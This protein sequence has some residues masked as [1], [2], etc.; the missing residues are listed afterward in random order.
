ME[1]KL[2]ATLKRRN[3]KSKRVFRLVGEFAYDVPLKDSLQQLLSN[4]IIFDEVCCM[5]SNGYVIPRAFCC[6]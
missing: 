2:G 4:K 3:Y 1:R 5:W 6:M